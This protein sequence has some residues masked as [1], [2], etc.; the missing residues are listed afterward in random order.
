[1]QE[2]KK[3]SSKKKGLES[4]KRVQRCLNSGSLW[5]D[6]GDLKTEDYLISVK[7]TAKKS[8]RLTKEILEEI[9]EQ[10]LD[11]NK[12][13]RIVIEIETDNGFIYVAGNVFKFKETK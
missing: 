7:H 6:K 10:A 1:M 9:W 13:P 2:P 5:F 4:E 8:F 3:K 12:Y 11:R